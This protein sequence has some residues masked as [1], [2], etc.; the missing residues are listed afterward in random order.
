V[1]AGK[2]LTYVITVTNNGPTS[3]QQVVVTATA[4]EGMTPD[5]LRT[6]GPPGTKFSRDGQI[7]RFD[8]VAEILPG[9]SVSYRAVVLTKQPGT[10][11]FVAES[12]A[13]GL[14]QP[15]STEVSTE[16]AEKR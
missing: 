8:P 6:E 5:S 3:H 15:L 10:Y 7:I 16:V 11:R 9:K 12:T 14:S 4:P 13:A 1:F 2:N